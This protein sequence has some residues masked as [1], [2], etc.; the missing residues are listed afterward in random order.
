MS[1]ISI[2]DLKRAILQQLS[3]QSSANKFN[4]IGRGESNNRGGI[5]Y[6]LSV[7]LSADERALA[8]RSFEE[9][10][11][12]G[13]IQ[14][15]YADLADPENWVAITDLGKQFL[16]RDLK[17][18]IDVKLALIGPHL[19][20]L[21]DGMKDA[22]GRTSPDAP[23]QAAHSARELLDQLL[24]EGAPADRKTRRE[25]FRYLMEKN[26]GGHASKGDLEIIEAS[27]KLV[28]A[29]HNKLLSNAHSRQS[30]RRDEVA[31]GIAA[32]ERIL[33]LIFRGE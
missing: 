30:V 28:E 21:R 27:W 8:A 18:A 4:L 9:L 15:T 23:R 19:V 7:S 14:A 25:R 12:D 11:R 31:A 29:E 16:Q 10:R 17:D 6:Q 26:R 13:Y 3:T 5:E 20:E 33:D 22:V 32:A 1:A 24:K 2:K